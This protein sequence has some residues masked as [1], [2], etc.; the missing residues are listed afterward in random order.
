MKLKIMACMVSLLALQA[1]SKIDDYMLGKDNTPAPK[2]LKEIKPKKQIAQQWTIPV[3]RDKATSSDYLKLAPVTKDGVIFTANRA[4]QVQAV[5]SRTG[6]MVWASALSHGVVSGPVV[7]GQVI[8]LGTNAAT[9]VLLEKSS[10]KQ[11]WETKVSS[12]LLARPVIHNDKVIAKT[13]DG[14]VYAFS[15]KDGKE[16]WKYDHGSPSLILKASASPVVLDNTIITGFSDGKMDA[17][18]MTNG[19][20]IWQRHIAFSSGVSDVERLVDIDADPVVVNRVAYVATY[21]GHIGALSLDSGQFL[22]QKPASIYKN[23]AFGNNA[24]FYTDSNDV[25][26]SL[27]AKTGAVNWKQTAFKA[28]GLTEPVVKGNDLVVADK[29]GYVHVLDMQTGEVV[30]RTRL[31][32]AVAKAPNVS[33]KNVYVITENGILNK[34][35]LG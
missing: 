9:L 6:S 30:G 29:E 5:D 22:W 18:D 3:G 10:G 28:R 23:M 20:L 25:L 33:G 24:L 15:I 31:S 16:L 11:R 26:W 14:K 4:G 13:I 27:D 34:L 12:E 21:Q 35:S 19:N 2:A 8:A 7:Q 32:G 17:L 1:C